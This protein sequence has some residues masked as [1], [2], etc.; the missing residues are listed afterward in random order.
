MAALDSG[1]CW[2][3]WHR[4]NSTGADALHMPASRGIVGPLTVRQSALAELCLQTL[5][6][7][8]VEF[9]HALSGLR[10]ESDGVTL[11][12][13]VRPVQEL[14]THPGMQATIGTCLFKWVYRWCIGTACAAV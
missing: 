6:R 13:Q 3:S 12:F 11:R 4:V 1:H 7:G 10:E 14:Q 2:C 8:S 9:G 5:P